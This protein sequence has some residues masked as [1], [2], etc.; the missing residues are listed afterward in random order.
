MTRPLLQVKN[1]VTYYHTYLGNVEAVRNISFSL[2]IGETV[3]IVGE[4]GSGKSALALSIMKLLDH[5][6]KIIQ[7]EVFFQDK[8]MLT[9]TEK[10][11]RIIRGDEISM[12]F[13]N[14]KVSLN[15]VFTIGN[16][17]IE[18]L[19]T[20]KKMNKNQAKD[21]AIKMLCLVGIQSAKQVFDRYPHELS[22]GMCQ[23]VS[24][25]MALSLKP[26]LLIADEPTSLLDVTVQAQILMLLKDLKEKENM[27][28][29]LISHDLGVVANTCNRIIVMYGGMIMEEGMTE[30]I[31][32]H[33]KH[34]YTKGLLDSIPNHSLGKKI[35]LTPIEGEPP[36]MINPQKGC[37]F[38][39]RCPYAMNIC[40][41]HIPETIKISD[42]HYTKCWLFHP[43]GPS[44]I[45]EGEKL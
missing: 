18:F 15:P 29:L 39:P 41:S 45:D 33:P 14:P 8:D 36:N 26:A 17:F 12:I 3:G 38:M 31:F 35:T 40:M 2:P 5:S 32:Y 28:M 16:Q 22:G 9:M 27:S 44:S 25:A 21:I 11:I 19:L 13:Q 43:N 23:K 4:S 42:N 1:L 20:H 10:E 7:G 24:I 6:G 34:P 30:E 37:P